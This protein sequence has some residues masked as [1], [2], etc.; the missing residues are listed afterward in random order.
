MVVQ[1][2]KLSLG[3]ECDIKAMQLC[4]TLLCSRN[5]CCLEIG[6]VLVSTKTKLFVVHLIWVRVIYVTRGGQHPSILPDAP[7]SALSPHS[8]PTSAI[9][10]RPHHDPHITVYA[11]V[12]VPEFE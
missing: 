4:R 8:S 1:V 9:I 3:G 11:H 12:K 10:F 2:S 6:V 5:R 7:T